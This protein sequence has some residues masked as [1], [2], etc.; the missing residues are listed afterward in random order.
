MNHADLIADL[1]SVSAGRPDATPIP[2]AIAGFTL[3]ASRSPSIIQH[4]IYQPIFCLVLQGA[5][6]AI[7][8][9]QTLMF[10][11]GRSLVVSLD[12]PAM[13][14]IIHASPAHPYLA[15]ALTL[16]LA[17]LRSLAADIAPVP[18]EKAGLAAATLTNDPAIADAMARLYRLTAQ[19]TAIPVLAPLIR[20][21]IHYWLL[22]SN[23]GPQLHGLL[24]ADAQQ[25]RIAK[26][27]REIRQNFATSL[28]VDR[29]AG[30]AGMS[31]SAFHS[32]FRTVTGTSPR[33]FQKQ[34]QLT[35]ARRLIQAAQCSVTTAAFEVGYESPTQF[36]RDYRNHF[37]LSPRQDRPSR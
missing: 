32:H 15:L 11:E 17:E 25:A 18:D 8:G 24:Q 36:S 29:L 23:H 2:T 6:Q 10:G 4:Q 7:I 33:Q 3:L 34:L 19:P 9:R 27:I 21:E 26:A 28:P 35:E 16:D 37:G 14:Q 1:A 22:M 13:S 30:I 5:K 20:R 31:L 12:L